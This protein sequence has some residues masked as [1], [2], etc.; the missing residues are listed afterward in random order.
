MYERS[1]NRRRF[2]RRM[3]NEPAWLEKSPDILERC[4]LLDLSKTGAR[5]SISDIYDLPES[6]TLRVMRGLAEP[7]VCHVIWRRDHVIGVE[8]ASIVPGKSKTTVVYKRWRG[9]L[10][11]CVL[12]NAVRSASADFV[13]L[14]VPRR[15]DTRLAART[16]SMI[17]RSQRPPRS[18]RII[19]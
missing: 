3:V 5:L 9:R 4:T 7:R 8:F 2:L 18:T 19:I 6:F 1:S 16:T 12:R 13:A 15:A 14:L 11:W 10:D 17:I